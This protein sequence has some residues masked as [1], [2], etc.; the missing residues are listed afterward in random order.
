M[1]LNPN[2]VS[3][4]KWIGDLLYEG[5]SYQDSLKAYAELGE[6]Y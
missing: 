5:M 6:V 3:I 4:Y 2:D 1:E